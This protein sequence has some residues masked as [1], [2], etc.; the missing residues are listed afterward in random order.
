MQINGYELNLTNEE[1]KNII[2]K[3]MRKIELIGPD[4]EAYQNLSESD[5]KALFHLLKAADIINDIALEQDHPLNRSLKEALKK[6]AQ[7]SE[8]AKNAYTLFQSLSIRIL[9]N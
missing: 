7:N 2:S 1:L 5:K 6:E 3:K 4:F 9:L 8:Y